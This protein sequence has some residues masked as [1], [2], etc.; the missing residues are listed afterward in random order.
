[1]DQVELIFRSLVNTAATHILR[2]GLDPIE[3]CDGL[4]NV[5]KAKGTSESL[6]EAFDLA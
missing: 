4:A 6:E 2:A 1:M 3:M 5:L